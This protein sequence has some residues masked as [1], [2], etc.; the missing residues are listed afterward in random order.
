ME[1]ISMVNAEYHGMFLIK[2]T[3]GHL[4]LTEE[5]KKTAQ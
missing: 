3:L 1:E 5:K 2:Q 4:Y